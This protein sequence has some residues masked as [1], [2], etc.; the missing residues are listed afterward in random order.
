[1]TAEL[2]LEF[3]VNPAVRCAC[4]LLLDT[5][6]SMAGQRIE[7]LNGALRTLVEELRQDRFTCRHSDIGIMTFDSEVQMVQDFCTA[8]KFEAPTL[9]AQ[10]QTYLGTA[11][12][13]ALD[14]LAAR[15]QLYKTDGIPYYRPW[16]FILTDGESQGEPP[17]ATEEAAERLARDQ[18]DKRVKVMPIGVAGA[19]LEVLGRLTRPVVPKRLDETKFTECLQWLK[20]S[21]EARSKSQ[22]PVEQVRLPS[23]EDWETA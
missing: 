23:P 7:S 14:R 13:A 9:T 20:N 11:V 3:A 8:D 22:N 2:N 17:G 21:L 12:V 10:G 4:L 5:S 15:K 1:M 16:L 18:A 6:G 19:N